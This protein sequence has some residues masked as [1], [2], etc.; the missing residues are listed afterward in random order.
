[1]TVFAALRAAFGVAHVVQFSA[2]IARTDL[3][4]RSVSPEV[5]WLV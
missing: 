4:H 1:V 5:A 3:V 2:F